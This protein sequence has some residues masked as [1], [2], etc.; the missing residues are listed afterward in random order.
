M[1]SQIKR[2]IVWVGNEPRLFLIR[3]GKLW[4]TVN[5]HFAVSIKGKE[6]TVENEPDWRTNTLT[7]TRITE[8]PAG[9]DYKE[10]LSDARE[11]IDFLKEV[12][13]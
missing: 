9:S 3:Q 7:A 4:W 11:Q 13:L 1:S 12:E 8:A 10:V 5:G 6:I 2:V